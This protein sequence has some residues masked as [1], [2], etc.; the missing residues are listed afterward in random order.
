MRCAAGHEC[1]SRPRDL[2]TGD[3]IC[4]TCAGT[5]GVLAEARFRELLAAAGATL[6]EPGW[7]GS[8][9]PCRVRCSAGHEV[10]PHPSSVLSGTGI[11][12][13]CAGKSWDAFYVV[14]D[15]AAGRIKF[16]ITSGDV[17]P[18]LA[19]HRGQ[20]YREVIRA[21][22]A[23]PGTT[24]PDIERAVRAALRLAG[25]QSVRGRE[26]YDVS[27]LALVLDVADNYPVS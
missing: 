27:A 22:T 6:L 19:F 10:S 16:G 21:L 11:C 26:Y 14:A 1:R 18:R 17:R 4:K 12:R 5:D 7:L 23:L 3:G 13:V 2:A 8:K 20:G 15:Q 9:T 24:A 25:I